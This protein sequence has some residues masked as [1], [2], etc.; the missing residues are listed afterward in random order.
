[1]QKLQSSKETT[2]VSLLKMNYIQSMK[3]LYWG[4]VLSH[5]FS[6]KTDF[7]AQAP[8]REVGLGAKQA[9]QATGAA[10]ASSVGFGYC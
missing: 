5:K 1:M 3:K 2:F 9:K 8:K 6:N 4:Y 10:R 7:M